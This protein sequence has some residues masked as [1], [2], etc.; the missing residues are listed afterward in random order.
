MPNMRHIILI[1]HAAAE[2][3]SHTDADSDRKLTELG[4]KQAQTAA[5]WLADH[6]QESP[7]ILCSTAERTRETAAALLGVY[8]KANVHYVAE[9]YE[10]TPAALMAVL[11]KDHHSPL[12][13]VGHNPGLESVLA[14]LCTGQSSAVRGM[15]TGAIAWLTAPQGA[16]AP[17]CA[18]LKQFWTP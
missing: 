5:R 2:A 14:L 17:G 11:D 8:P 18:E 12:V 10:A 7:R 4:Q 6:L 15:S 3:S 9:I 16:V 13:L 1:R